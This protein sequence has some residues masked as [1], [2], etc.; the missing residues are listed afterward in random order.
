MRI[1]LKDGI[2]HL[3]QRTSTNHKRFVLAVMILGTVLRLLRMN[4]AVTY[5]EALTYV[6]YAGNSLGFLFSDYTYTSNHILYAALAR[7][8]MLVFGVHPWTLRLPA[9][10]AGLLVMPLGYAFVRNVFNRHIAVIYLCLLAVSGPMVEYSA[11]ARGYS[12][13]WLFTLCALLAARH[14]IKT[15]NMVSALLIALFCGLGMWASPSMIYPAI[16]V[17]AWTVFRIMVS[18]QSTV[19]QR[20]LKVLGSGIVALLLVALVYAPVIYVHS[21]DQL[22]HHPSLVD[23][24]WA[25]LSETHQDR[26]FD[27]WAYFTATTSTAIAFAGVVAV[28]YAAYASLKYRFLIFG[29]VL[30]IIPVVLVQR[31]VAPPAVWIFTLLIFHLGTAIGLFF[32]LKVVRD[33]M[34]PNFSKGKRSLVA[35][36]VVLLIF[37]WAGLRGSP[38]PVERFPDARTA[39]DWLADHV[40]EGD[41]ICAQTPWDVPVGFYLGCAGRDKAIWQEGP[42]AGGRLL[43]LVAPGHSQTLVSVLRHAGL[44]EKEAARME[45]VESWGRLELF[46][47]R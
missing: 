4:G 18:Y 45:E 15:D 29:M 38:D 2:R 16:M 10:L 26:A 7:L 47:P 41:R 39:A 21:L 42:A 32:L 13:V 37:G 9:L 24:T 11:M 34:V 6:N 23:H 12:L 8:S 22:L 40:Q 36:L 31:D 35:S 44:S 43:A 28:G 25:H 5:D 33:K 46:A 30:G 20:L 14:C 3:V 19:R 1:D 17:Y 27:L